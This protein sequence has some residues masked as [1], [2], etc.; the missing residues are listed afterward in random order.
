MFALQ[1]LW[2]DLF[3]TEDWV[4]LQPRQGHQE[5]DDGVKMWYTAAIASMM[6][7]KV[8]C[9]RKTQLMY[10]RQCQVV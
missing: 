1:S 7:L 2:A 8:E 9:E 5:E 6:K 4:L 10:H 3:L